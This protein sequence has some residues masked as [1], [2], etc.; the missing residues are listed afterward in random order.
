MKKTMLIAICAAMVLSAPAM[1][2]R[3][4]NV[5]IEHGPV[6]LFQ[7]YPGMTTAETDN[8]DFAGEA[9]LN[10]TIS[11]VPG[12]FSLVPGTFEIP[13]GT[14]ENGDPIYKVTCKWTNFISAFN[15]GY[16]GDLSKVSLTN[17]VLRKN[18]TPF[19]CYMDGEDFIGGRTI[20]QQGTD[21]IRTWWPL[22]YEVPGT[23]FT[24]SI[25]YKTP[26]AWDDDGAEGPNLPHTSHQDIWSW[27]VCAD[28]PHLV[29]LIDLFYEL[30]SGQFQQPLITSAVLYE[31]L[32]ADLAAIQALVAAREEV[33][34]DPYAYAAINADLADAINAF[35]L[36]VADACITVPCGTDNFLAPGEQQIWGGGIRNTVENPACCKILADIE[37]IAE[38]L[39][40]NMTAK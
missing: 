37:Y 24:L 33:S 26:T 10:D 17:I 2:A 12:V 16:N 36:K 20:S 32:K 25:T 14:D 1:A 29:N 18:V 34:S 35:N 38:D 19:S 40:V 7:A 5:P 23:T 21:K 22:M 27:T 3:V 4:A 8:Y 30:P 28:L 15:G 9:R 39:A 6:C 11:A 31:E 13:F